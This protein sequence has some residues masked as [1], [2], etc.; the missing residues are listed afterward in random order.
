MPKGKKA[1]TLRI[2]E[3]EA[4]EKVLKKN[5]HIKSSGPQSINSDNSISITFIAVQP[6]MFYCI[7]DVLNQK[8]WHLF[9]KHTYLIW[10]GNIHAHIQEL[11]FSFNVF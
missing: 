8:L 3:E 9:Q 1:I 7:K 11:K 4:F 2:A 6:K 5:C 10:T